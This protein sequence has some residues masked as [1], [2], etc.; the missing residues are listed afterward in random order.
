MVL[1][2]ARL[3]SKFVMKRGFAEGVLPFKNP[4]LHL[5]M[6]FFICFSSK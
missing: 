6:N 4:R 1:A 5:Y 2:S 3:G